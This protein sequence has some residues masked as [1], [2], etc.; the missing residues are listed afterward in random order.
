MGVVGVLPHVTRAPTEVFSILICFLSRPV[1]L[2]YETSRDICVFWSDKLISNFNAFNNIKITLR[3]YMGTS[4][5]RSLSGLYTVV[6][7][8]EGKGG[9]CLG[10]PFATVMCKVPCFQR[11]PTATAMHN[12]ATLLSNG[13]PTAVVLCK[14]LAFKGAQVTVMHFSF[15]ATPNFIDFYCFIYQFGGSEVSLEC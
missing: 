5:T 1:C 14:Y 4:G 9:T 15:K 12:W 10:P 7:V 11:G 8:R 2:G 6:C 13:P 3:V